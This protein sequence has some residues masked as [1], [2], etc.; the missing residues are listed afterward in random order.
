VKRESGK[1]E[2]ERGR[3]KRMRERERE[4]EVVT[5]RQFGPSFCIRDAVRGL[6]LPGLGQAERRGKERS[7][8]V[9]G[10]WAIYERLDNT[11]GKR[12]ELD[13]RN[14]KRRTTWN[15]KEIPL[16]RV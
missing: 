10:A 15:K 9:A 12:K 3:K 2:T 11:Q 13:K 4:R 7:V 14:K 5:S 1:R 6:R 16:K 8:D